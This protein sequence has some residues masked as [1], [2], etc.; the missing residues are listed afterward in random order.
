MS[1]TYSEIEKTI[2]K[3][4]SY[5][6]YE[7]TNKDSVKTNNYISSFRI[8]D[9]HFNENDCKAHITLKRP[10][11][12]IGSKGVQITGIIER[13]RKKLELPKFSINI[14]ENT[15]DN[16]FIDFVGLNRFNNDEDWD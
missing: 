4:I 8:T 15:I 3:E 13:L 6:V 1:K 10:G 11:L 5:Y 2:L 16:Y 12:L 7:S 14:I 9:I